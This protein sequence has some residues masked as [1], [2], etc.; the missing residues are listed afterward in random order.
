VIFNFNVKVG[1]PRWRSSSRP[2][3]RHCHGARDA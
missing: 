1:K 2:G 3:R